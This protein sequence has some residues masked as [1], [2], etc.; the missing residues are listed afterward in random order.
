MRKPRVLVDSSVFHHAIEFQGRWEDTGV[1]LWGGRNGVPVQTGR[2]VSSWEPIE[3]KLEKGGPQ[4]KYIA[5]LALAFQKGQWEAHT[6]DALRIERFFPAYSGSRIPRNRGANYGDVSWFAKVECRGHVTLEELSFTV[7]GQT[8]P[9]DLLRHLLN[10]SHDGE[11]LEIRRAL[12]K[13]GSAKRASQDAWHINT[14]IRLKMDK[15]LTCDA[16]LIGQARSITDPTLRKKIL[17]VLALPSELCRLMGLVEM[18]DAELKELAKT[19]G[20]W[21]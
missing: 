12:E 8:E 9:I 5:A 13:A 19:L 2:I 6:S 3:I 17:D 11:Y 7:P 21:I 16:R 1:V 15:F 20:I 4:G 18:S 10:N 14:A